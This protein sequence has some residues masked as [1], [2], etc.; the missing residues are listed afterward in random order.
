VTVAGKD[1]ETTMAAL[2]TIALVAMAFGIVFGA[3]LKL[4]SAIRREDRIRG[5]LRR[6]ALDPRDR[7]VR[8]LV[9][10][11]SSGWD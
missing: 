11:H 9:G 1:S 8:S 2:I 6:R 10:A 3:F 7:T 5:S 4:S